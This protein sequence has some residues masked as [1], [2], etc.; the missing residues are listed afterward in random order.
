MALNSPLHE[1]H[2]INVNT[3]GIPSGYVKIAIENG[4]INSGFTHERWWFSLAMSGV[5]NCP[6]LGI[7]DITL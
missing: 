7:L 5:G 6:I 2:N 4:H 1:T 3:H